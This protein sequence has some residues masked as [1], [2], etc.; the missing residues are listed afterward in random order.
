MDKSFLPKLQLRIARLF[1]DDGKSIGDYILAFAVGIP[2]VLLFLG[3]VYMAA[4]DAQAR[5]KPAA[6]VALLVFLTWPMGLI[7][8]VIFRPDEKDQ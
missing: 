4:R 7:M 3:T 8:W 5:G 6:L 1:M 2:F